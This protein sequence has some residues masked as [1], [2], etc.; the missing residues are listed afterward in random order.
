[1]ER[2][3]RSEGRRRA[4][5]TQISSPWLDTRA[6]ICRGLGI[7]PP[8]S[9][10]LLLLFRPRNVQLQLAAHFLQF[11]IQATHKAAKPPGVL[12]EGN[13]CNLRIRFGV[14]EVHGNSEAIV[15][16]E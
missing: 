16:A 4:N 2:C 12:F 1:M 15:S 6:K 9:I 8:R 3:Y 7:R 5:S 10:R 14:D 11:F 13:R